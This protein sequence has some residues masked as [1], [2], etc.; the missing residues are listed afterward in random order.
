[1]S[2]DEFRVVE[3]EMEPKFAEFHDRIMQNV[4]LFE[5]IE[6]VYNA[7]VNAGLSPEQG[8]LVWN[9]YTDFLRE[10]AKL[11]SGQKATV[12]KINKRLAELYTKFSNNLL[13][14][15]ENYVL[16][17]TKDQLGGLPESF[18]KATAEAAA[19]RETARQVRGAEYA[20][21]DGSVSLLLHPPGP[22]RE[23][24]A[25]LLQPRRQWR[26]LRQQ[27]DHHRNPEAARRADK[28]A[29]IRDVCAPGAR[30]TGGKDSRGVDGADDRRYGLRL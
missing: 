15:E 22:A 13:H 8:R 4:R 11:T 20:F 1:M 30:E 25:H 26:C 19:E 10:G 14:D 18:V 6:K 5:R 7:R 12:A 9:Y 21:L 27:Q 2:S 28:A 29:G 24:L 16:Y 17:L 3:E 23:S